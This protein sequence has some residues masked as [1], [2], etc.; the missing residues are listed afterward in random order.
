M[1][2]A[3]ILVPSPRLAWNDYTSKSRVDKE[4]MVTWSVQENC[5]DKEEPKMDLKEKVGF[6]RHGEGMAGGVKAMRR[7]Q[8]INL[9]VNVLC[10]WWLYIPLW[11]ISN[12]VLGNE[13]LELKLTASQTHSAFHNDSRLPILGREVEGFLWK[14]SEHWNP[15]TL[16][17]RPSPSFVAYWFLLCVT[18]L[19]KSEGTLVTQIK[20][21]LQEK[22]N[23][24]P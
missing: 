11:N 10:M 19:P 13:D 17:L 6:G 24:S 9:T 23:C 21:S 12:H 14:Y 3:N 22:I 18:G 2:D 20:N 16:I 5:K 15:G 7:Y 1:T 4:T 8:H